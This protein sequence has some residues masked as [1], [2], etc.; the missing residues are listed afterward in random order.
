MKII[1]D[2]KFRKLLYGY[3]LTGKE[4]LQFDDIDKEDF[5]SHDFFRYKGYV[6]DPDEFLR[7]ENNSDPE[8]SKYDGYSNDTYFS[9]ILIKYNEDMES[10]KIARYFLDN[11]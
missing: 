2:N 7:I 3:E 11:L 9:G 6:Y 8:F 10:I 4:K 1:T 5:D